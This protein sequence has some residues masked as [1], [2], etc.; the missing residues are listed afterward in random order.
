MSTSKERF[1]EFLKIVRQEEF[2]LNVDPDHLIQTAAFLLARAKG[3]KI[4][5]C[6][7]V[8]LYEECYKMLM[9]SIVPYEEVP[10]VA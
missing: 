1:Q 6:G 7:D 2:R 3:K 8:K 10:D 4:V 5:A 9:D